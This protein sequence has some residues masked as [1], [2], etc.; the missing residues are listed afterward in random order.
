MNSTHL[1]TGECPLMGNALRQEFANLIATRGVSTGA[2]RAYWAKQAKKL[3]LRNTENG[4]VFDKK[5]PGSSETKTEDE[6][7]N[8]SSDK[9]DSKPSETTKSDGK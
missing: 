4:I 1:Q 2:G 6:N 5:E 9:E 7:D 3:G 8:E